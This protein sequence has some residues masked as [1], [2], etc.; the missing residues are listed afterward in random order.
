MTLRKSNSPA[1]RSSW[2]A[3]HPWSRL[4]GSGFLDLWDGDAI[5]TVPSINISDEKDH[6]AVEMAAPGMKKEDFNIDLSGNLL[7]ISAEKESRTD[8]GD[9]KG[10]EKKGKY[11]RRE[12]NY[13]SFSRSFTL[14]DNADTEKIEA[15]YQDGILHLRIP[16]KDEPKKT[17][18]HKIKVS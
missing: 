1:R 12:Y 15:R 4:F 13:S 11:S 10:E 14:P 5:D 18:S 17:D 6:F 2:P 7:T 3:Q 8:D 9:E 16:K